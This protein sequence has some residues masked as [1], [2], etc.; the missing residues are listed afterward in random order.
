MAKKRARTAHAAERDH[1]RY[2]FA[3]VES[4][5]SN[6]V[7]QQHGFAKL[8]I[9]NKVKYECPR[10]RIRLCRS[11]AFNHIDKYY[12]SKRCKR[13]KRLEWTM[14][15]HLQP[16]E[17]RSWFTTDETPNAADDGPGWNTPAHDQHA[18]TTV[19][20]NSL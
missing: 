18:P 3:E 15:L 5:K 9:N 19:C 1:R 2:T 12:L 16:W 20:P 17:Q 7:L 4:L 10:C 11:S 6:D 8:A 13:V 14:A